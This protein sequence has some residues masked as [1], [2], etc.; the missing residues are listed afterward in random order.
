MAIKLARLPE[1]NPVKVTVNLSPE[2]HQA[3]GDYAA[4]Y[5]ETYG[6]TEG[7]ADLIPY[8]LQGFLESDR[9]FKGRSK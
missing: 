1:R 4:L 7:V 3:L 5:A 8:M 6:Q 2:L 9:T